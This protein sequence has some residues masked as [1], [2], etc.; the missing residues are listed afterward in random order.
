MFV[1]LLIGARYC[2]HEMQLCRV[3]LLQHHLAS[4]LLQG[5]LIE[6]QLLMA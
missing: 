6:R 1:E 2:V 3:E 5:L 4:D